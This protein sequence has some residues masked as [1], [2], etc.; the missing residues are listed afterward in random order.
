MKCFAGLTAELHRLD[1]TQFARH[2][3]FYPDTIYPYSQRFMMKPIHKARASTPTQSSDM[4]LATPLAEPQQFADILFP[5]SQQVFDASRSC[6]FYTFS[7]I[8]SYLQFIEESQLV[9]VQI[10]EDIRNH[11]SAALHEAEAAQ[12][13][14]A[15]WTKLGQVSTKQLSNMASRW[16]S[17]S[18]RLLGAQSHLIEELQAQSA[19]MTHQWIQ[20]SVAVSAT[21]AIPSSKMASSPLRAGL[22][23]GTPSAWAQIAK[24]WIESGQQ[25]T[26]HMLK[27]HV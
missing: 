6:C 9:R 21:E 3:P 18:S 23:G 11:C 12:S 1:Q 15:L 16:T 27:E 2:K 7:A 13:L 26:N 14:E 17:L 5:W 10:L 24:Q 22:F 8:A 19:R 20:S 25:A 4:D